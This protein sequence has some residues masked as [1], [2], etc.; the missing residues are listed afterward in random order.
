MLNYG[1]KTAAD[2]R[3]AKGARGA[4]QDKGGTRA[5]LCICTNCGYSRSCLEQALC[6]IDGCPLC[7]SEMK[8]V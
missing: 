4:T 6:S 5:D 3:D 8:I 7:G 2:D 1:R